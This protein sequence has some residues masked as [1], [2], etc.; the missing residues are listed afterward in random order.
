MPLLIPDIIKKR[1][2]L[3]TYPYSFT[4]N[5]FKNFDSILISFTFLLIEELIKYNMIVHMKLRVLT[6]WIKLL[7]CN[8]KIKCFFNYSCFFCGAID[9]KI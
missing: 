1:T 2:G 9:E 3:R 5:M 7:R 8:I 6:A 4:K